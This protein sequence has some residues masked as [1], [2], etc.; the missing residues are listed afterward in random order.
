MVFPICV[1]TF[2][3]PIVSST[4]TVSVGSPVCIDPNMKL[5]MGLISLAIFLKCIYVPILVYLISPLLLDF[6]ELM[7]TN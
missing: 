3:H 6:L 2:H 5:Q 1:N 4:S 7:Y